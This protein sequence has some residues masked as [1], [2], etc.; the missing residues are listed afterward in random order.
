MFE[1][2]DERILSRSQMGALL[3]A[4]DEA[5]RNEETEPTAGLA[6]S[7]ADLGFGAGVE[8][9]RHI[10]A[11]LVVL[12]LLLDRTIA[13]AR[14][15]D[16][17]REIEDTR[18]EG[19]G[20]QGTGQDAGAQETGQD[21]GAQETGQGAGAQETGQDAGAQGTGQG[22]GAQGTG[23]GAGMAPEDAALLDTPEALM[24]ALAAR[25]DRIVYG[26]RFLLPDDEIEGEGQDKPH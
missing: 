25:V 22:A 26:R 7:L 17:G 19:A 20:A 16:A 5:Q 23:Q 15:A 1:G 12:Q 4:I 11:H 2:L 21:A 24:A 6:F 3:F 8:V 13:R 14:A 10:V 18:A 9:H